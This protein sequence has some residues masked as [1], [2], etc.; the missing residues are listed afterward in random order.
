MEDSKTM[1]IIENGR[2]KIYLD[3]PIGK[4]AFGSVY[5]AENS[6]DMEIYAAKII[7]SFSS[8]SSSEIQNLMKA[9]SKS[10]HIVRF[11]DF[12]FHNH[13]A[14][15]IT[16][17]CESNLAKII[18][19]NGGR[20]T[21]NLA[22]L[23]FIELIMGLKEIHECGL[24]H[25]DIKIDNI[26]F[27]EGILKIGDFGFSTSNLVAE[28]VVGSPIYM[29]PELLDQ[30]VRLN[31]NKHTGNLKPSSDTD[32][33]SMDIPNNEKTLKKN[34]DNNEK[35]ND[36]NSLKT[37]EKVSAEGIMYDKNIDVWSCGMV[38]YQMIFGELP[39]TI[40][41]S[42]NVEKDFE[43]LSNK[44]KSLNEKI[45]FENKKFNIS[46]S[47]K[48][49]IVN[50]LKP[51]SSERFKFST[52]WRH[53]WITEGLIR[54]NGKLNFE[55][56]IVLSNQSQIQLSSIGFRS[57][58]N[59]SVPKNRKL[60]EAY[61]H[62]KNKFNN[63][64]DHVKVLTMLEN[65]LLGI[66]DKSRIVF[67]AGSEHISSLKLLMT[68]I[69]NVY[70]LIKRRSIFELG[71]LQYIIGD[72]TLT[73]IFIGSDGNL[74]EK[75]INDL[76]KDEFDALKSDLKNQIE[77]LENDYETKF[78]ECKNTFLAKLKFDDLKKIDTT[79]PFDSFDENYSKSLMSQTMTLCLTIMKEDKIDS[80]FLF[81]IKSFYAFEKIYERRVECEDFKNL[82][83]C[84]E[85]MSDVDL[86]EIIQT[87]LSVQ[88]LN[89]GGSVGSATVLG[90]I[91]VLL[92]AFIFSQI[93]KR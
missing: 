92:F 86:S 51:S 54:Y 41:A 90:L 63:T 3:E 37:T 38:L 4:G 77:S 21:E 85:N 75:I 83:I 73:A 87:E 88:D 79:N 10:E 91:L 9:S 67:R 89:R 23:Y 44:I 24:M 46:N 82:A 31:K 47:L 45:L 62:L 2:F 57:K 60:V 30:A 93:G 71:K 22:Q 49:L 61:N 25:R 39:F 36:K 27:K 35:I 43:N 14:V 65:R 52:I 18:K 29:S 56:Y 84:F 81:L 28:S 50:I 11:V 17:Y 53:E 48:D 15:I 40:E 74:C 33:Y 59:K 80:S 5:F 68:K 19:D 70:F 42:G 55:K 76:C 6:N 26:Y 66:L 20:L 64:S 58:I 34:M 12:F 8:S 69:S 13:K 32:L 16:E 7:D 1:N 78:A 72:A